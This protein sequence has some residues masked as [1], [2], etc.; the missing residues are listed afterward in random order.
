MKRQV[1]EFLKREHDLIGQELRDLRAG[2]RKVV[3]LNSGEHDITSQAI[4]EAEA[5]WTR[6]AEMIAA[7]ESGVV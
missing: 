1:L 6:F 5:R 7:Y 2:E 4:G 3:R